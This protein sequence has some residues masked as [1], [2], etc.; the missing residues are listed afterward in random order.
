MAQRS[1][2]NKIKWQ[3]EQIDRYFERIYDSLRLIEEMS[4]ERVSDINAVV[5]VIMTG[6]ITCQEVWEKLR[7]RL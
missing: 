3:A 4:Q 2:R 5:P 7:E 6:L 1:T